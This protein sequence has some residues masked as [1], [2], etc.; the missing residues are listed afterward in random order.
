MSA[1]IVEL[2]RVA[3]ARAAI[4]QTVDVSLPEPS[5]HL[6]VYLW[7]LS[8]ASRAITGQRFAAREWVGPRA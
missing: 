8:A 4:S 1:R 3:A 5:A 6:G 7:L 2:S